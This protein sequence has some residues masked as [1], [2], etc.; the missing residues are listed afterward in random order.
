[1]ALIYATVM[2]NNR[3]DKMAL[4]YANAVNKRMNH[5]LGGKPSKKTSVTGCPKELRELQS[6]RISEGSEKSGS[7][8]NGI[9]Q[10]L[11]KQSAYA[12]SPINNSPCSH[13]KSSS[14]HKPV[15]RSKT[16]VGDWAKRKSDDDMLRKISQP[17]MMHSTIHNLDGSQ[18]PISCSSS[19]SIN[20]EV[21]K[22]SIAKKPIVQNNEIV[23]KLEKVTFSEDPPE[24]RRVSVSLDAEQWKDAE[25]KEKEGPFQKMKR[26]ISKLRFTGLGSGG[27]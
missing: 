2:Q 7:L 22:S 18:S 25:K 19:N 15:Q 23:Q 20:K 17:V 14:K 8:D 9:A 24:L 11:R 5:P 21:K 13:K 4:I 10:P 3:N 16:S 27:S 1:M 12:K 6:S 26:K